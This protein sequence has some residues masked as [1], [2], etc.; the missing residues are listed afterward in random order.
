MSA[1]QIESFDFDPQSIVHWG[2]ASRRH[3][4]WPVVYTLDD[5][6]DVYV[7]E[8]L[9]GVAR[10][11]QHFA[12]SEKQHLTRARVVID[13]TFNKSV[14]LDLESFLIRLFAGDGKFRILNRNDGITDA[15]YYSRQEYRKTFL[16]IFDDLRSE[17][18]FSRTIPEIE[19]SDLFKLSPFKALT[20]DQAIAAEDIVEGLFDDLEN[21]TRS[22]IVVEGNPGTGKTVLAIYL[23]K[24]LSDIAHAADDDH[25]DSDSMFS[26]FFTPGHREL[27]SGFKVGLVIPQQSLRASIKSVFH[28]VSGLDANSVISPFD[29]GE[30]DEAFDLLIVDEAHR[31]NRRSAQAMGT[32]TKQFADIN[33]KLFGGSGQ[34]KSQLDW[35]RAQSTHQLFLVDVDQAVRPADLP[36]EELDALKNGAE[37]HGRLYR[38]A[39]QMRVRAEAD[40][41]G[42]IKE[43]VSGATPDPQDFGEYDLRLFDDFDDMRAAILEREAEVGLS[44]LLGGYAWK[45]QSRSDKSAYDIEIG[46]SKLRWNSTTVDWVNSK[47]SVEEVGSI[48]TIQ[49]YDLNYAGVIIGADLEYDRE[50]GFTIF[51]RKRYFDARG[52]ANNNLLGI[53]FS[54]EDLLGYVRNIYAVLLTRGIRGTYIYVEDPA[55]REHF[56]VAFASLP[57]FRMPPF[58]MA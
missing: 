6:R 14:C 33:S 28:R 29:V 49:G 27:L 11:Q 10:M 34:Q 41:V 25:V 52:K 37:S 32:L 50:R 48:H 58:G 18:Y 7:G 51:N 12:N 36:K 8:T 57:K 5:S 56:K 42:Y 30:S 4:N 21:R 46:R 19:N 24:L 43:L 9:N 47:R 16:E 20:Q 39:T 22:S 13:E 45:W 2:R 35:I 54:D 3:S 40:Y 44:R 15:D 31:L 26:D 1:F 38:L 53:T 55:L 17:G 23:M